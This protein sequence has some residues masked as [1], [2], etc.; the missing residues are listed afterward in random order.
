MTAMGA[1]AADMATVR[2]EISKRVAELK[3]IEKRI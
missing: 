3:V 1:S 2:G